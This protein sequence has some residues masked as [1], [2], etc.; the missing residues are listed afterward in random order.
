MLF[1]FSPAIDPAWAPGRGIVVIAFVT[2]IEMAVE[3]R[4]GA[5]DADVVDN[6]GEGG[7]AMMRFPRAPIFPATIGFFENFAAYR[8]R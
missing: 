3:A 1:I 4:G 8:E 6:R 7:L 5:D 2:A